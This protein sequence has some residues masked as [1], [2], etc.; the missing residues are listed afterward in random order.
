MIKN[1]YKQIINYLSFVKT[2]PEQSLLLDLIFKLEFHSV[3]DIVRLDMCG[4]ILCDKFID[5]VVIPL[6]SCLPNLGYIRFANYVKQRQDFPFLQHS[7]PLSSAGIFRLLCELQAYQIYAFANGMKA[8]KHCTRIDDDSDSQDDPKSEQTSSRANLIDEFNLGPMHPIPRKRDADTSH[9]DFM[10]QYLGSIIVPPTSYS[11]ISPFSSLSLRVSFGTYCIPLPHRRLYKMV[12]HLAFLRRASTL[13]N[14]NYPLPQTKTI[15]DATI[16]TNAL[17]FVT[18]Y[19]STELEAYEFDR[20]FMIENVPWLFAKEFLLFASNSDSEFAD[21][22]YSCRCDHCKTRNA[23]FIEDLRYLAP[24]HIFSWQMLSQMDDL[25]EYYDKSSMWRCDFV[26]TPLSPMHDDLIFIVLSQFPYFYIAAEETGLSCSIILKAMSIMKKRFDFGYE[27][28]TRKTQKGS[29]VISELLETE[30]DDS[31]D[32]FE[33]KYRQIMRSN[34]IFGSSCIPNNTLSFVLD[35]S[36]ENL[37]EFC[38][39]TPQLSSFPKDIE[40]LWHDLFNVFSTN[41]FYI[42]PSPKIQSCPHSEQ[43]PDLPKSIDCFESKFEEEDEEYSFNDFEESTN[44]DSSQYRY[45][46]V[47]IDSH[48]IESSYTSVSAIC[49]LI[50]KIKYLDNMTTQG[51]TS[52]E[53]LAQGRSISSAINTLH[54][55]CAINERESIRRRNAIDLLKE[56]MK[57]MDKNCTIIP[58]PF[59]PFSHVSNYESLMTL[60]QIE[61]LFDWY[62]GTI[63]D[64]ISTFLCEYISPHGFLQPIP[65]IEQQLDSTPFEDSIEIEQSEMST[66]EMMV[67]PPFLTKCTHITSLNLRMSSPFK[68]LYILNELLLSNSL[69]HIKKLTIESCTISH[70]LVP[71][72]TSLLRNEPFLDIRDLSTRVSRSDNFKYL[73][74]LNLH[75]FVHDHLNDTEIE[76]ICCSIEKYVPI[77]KDLD[78]Q[79][80]KFTPKQKLRLSVLQESATNI[81]LELDFDSESQIHE[82]SSKLRICVNLSSIDFGFNNS[83]I[84]CGSLIP[85]LCCLH[86]LQSLTINWASGSFTD[87]SETYFLGDA[88]KSMPMLN[89]ICLHYLEFGS[90]ESVEKFVDGLCSGP[91]FMIDFELCTVL[92]PF[93][94]CVEHFARFIRSAQNS[95]EKFHLDLDVPF[96]PDLVHLRSF[97]GSLIEFPRSFA[98][99]AHLSTLILRGIPS[100]DL[101][102]FKVFTDIVSPLHIQYINI[103]DCYFIG[104]EGALYMANAFHDEPEDEYIITMREIGCTHEISSRQIKRLSNGNVCLQLGF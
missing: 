64:L 51:S 95:L 11:S 78:I 98:G 14:P 39:K 44:D 94:M 72:F 28:R 59:I 99:C 80:C 13:L 58:F 97:C 33:C 3:S 102:A 21:G 63:N 87:G 25:K 24:F 5:D 10:D 88:I 57:Q 18:E 53:M 41:N 85:S 54:L 48:P 61:P 2:I 75:R 89:K 68:T 47:A 31:S 46:S 92:I 36:L 17:H 101:P 56:E 84:R 35:I 69:V 62:D 12:C 9:K 96:E 1:V 104:N 90:E 67:I 81:K 42:L 23:L 4:F 22:R 20:V 34:C 91:K 79:A 103:S 65:Q 37:K 43:Y 66:V 55:Q 83:G 8:F 32:N 27:L 29:E 40:S 26:T 30:L 45:D 60:Y 73:E 93:P 70:S 77:L 71:V 74:S 7:H 49:T 82:F 38:S 19:L 52:A 86:K 50:P 100:F 76:D 15:L 16:L 6:L